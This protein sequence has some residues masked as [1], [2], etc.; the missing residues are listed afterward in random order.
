[1]IAANV[2][3]AESGEKARVPVVYRIHEPP[4]QEKIMAFS[5]YLRTIGFSFAKGQVL[6]PGVFNRI[7]DQAKGT[8]HERAMNDVVLRTQ[9][10][11]VYA[12]NNLGHFGLNLQRY[13][14]FTSPIRRYADL[15]VHRAL[16]RGLKFGDDGLTNREEAKLGE[17]SEHISQCER[18]A[19]AAE[20]DSNDRYVA[21]FL[22][23]RVGAVFEARVTGV[24][25]FGL[26]VR[27][28]ETGAE[29]LLPVREL[30]FEYF[31]H[32]ERRHALVGERS[33]TIYRMGDP[34]TV[35]LEEAAPLTGG[36]RF[37]LAEAKAGS[38]RETKPR[39]G[40]PPRFGKKSKPM[41]GRK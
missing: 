16:I 33:N 29:G 17:I 1:M 34:L 15:L 13:A 6:K 9:S 4:S 36:L 7:L 38:T 39:P 32:D 14:H 30:G 10:Q 25:R 22:A 5:D 24:T 31:R 23:D 26:F 41:R 18:R 3:A 8:P 27:L 35:K 11:A 20:R 19:M 21:A 37:S 2:A 28:I 12:P 40:Q